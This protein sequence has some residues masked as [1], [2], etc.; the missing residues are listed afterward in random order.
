LQTNNYLEELEINYF[1]LTSN[2]KPVSDMNK[3]QKIITSIIIKP[4]L[5]HTNSKKISLATK[6]KKSVVNQP[7]AKVS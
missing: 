6:N 1:R 7:D 4:E 2:P 3:Y 5:I